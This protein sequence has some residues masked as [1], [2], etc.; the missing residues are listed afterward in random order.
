MLRVADCSAAIA[1]L[2][3]RVSACSARSVSATFWNATSTVLRY[4]AV[5]CA[6]VSS[7]ACCLFASVPASNTVCATLPAIVQ[8]A[9]PGE[10]SCDSAVA[11]LPALPVS[12]ICGRR[13]AIATPICALVACRLASAA[14]MSGRWRT[15]SAGTLKRQFARQPERREL[16]CRRR[17]LARKPPGQERQQVALLGELPLQRR[18]QQPRLRDRRLLRHHVRQRDLPGLVLLLQH[19]EQLRLDADQPARRRDLAAQRRFLDRRERDVGGE[20]EIDAL[21]LERLRP[22][23]A[24]RRPR[25]P[26]RAAEHVGHE[27]DG[28]LRGV[29]AVRCWRRTRRWSSAPGSGLS[30][31]SH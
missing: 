20:R 15:R 4:C 2:T 11:V 10:N 25:S 9:V 17:L 31:G 18:Q 27:G 23:P 29:Q 30:A 22:R 24:R 6:K 26:P 7:A 5:A 16:K 12:V 14:R 21:A 28:D 1:A 8:N 19:A 13:L 3:A